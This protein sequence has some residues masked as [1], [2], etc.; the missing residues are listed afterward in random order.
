MYRWS[1]CPG[2]VKLSEGMPN[3]SSVAAQEGT[4]AHEFVGLAM[5]RAFS[6]NKNPGLV[7][8]EAIDHLKVYTDYCNCL[9]ANNPYHIE[10]AF[11]MSDIFEDG[12]GT[13]DF[14]LYQ[15]SKR[16]LHVVD[17][18]NGIAL[19]VEAKDNLQ[20]Q[21]YAL[22]ALTTLNYPCSEVTMT[23][24]QPRAYHPA[25][26]IRSW[27]VPSM[28]FIDFEADLIAFAKATKKKKAK[29]KA[30][31]HCL[32]CPAKIICPQKHSDNLA[33]AKKEF[34]HYREPSKDFEPITELADDKA[35]VQSDFL[36]DMFS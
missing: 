13:A 4:A 26:P 7:M 10:H 3:K 19:P 33:G 22:G 11:D 29:L 23:I 18:K 9:R 30:G 20:L 34:R 5:K 28:H 17:Y 8:Q 35:T 12:Y 25:G 31:E 27:T 15:K 21:Y 24:V 2:S 14:V 16:M 1:V 32:F 36:N 6:E